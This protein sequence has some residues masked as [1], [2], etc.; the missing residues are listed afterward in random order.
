MKKDRFRFLKKLFV[1][2]LI[3]LTSAAMAG[4]EVTKTIANGLTS[5]QSGQT[6]TYKLQYR[7]ASTT[8]DFYST[9]LTDI[10]PPGIEF[11]SLVGTVHM[12]SYTYNAGTR[13]L[14]IFFIDPL[15][16]GSTG[17][18]DVNVRFTPGSTPPG[19][20]ATNTATLAATNAP[21]F[22]SPPVTI[23]ATATNRA[24]AGKSL[25]G[26]SVPLDQNVT[27]QISANNNQTA[28][29][30][31]ATAVT[32]TDLL[33]PAA[34]F[35]SAS[36][37]GAYDSLSHTVTWTTPTLNAGSSFT[38]TLTL[39]FPSSA[40]TLGASV[41]N[42]LN[43]TLTPLGSAPITLTAK[44]VNTIVAPLANSSF[45]K[46][47]N[48]SYV[49]E[50][51]TA[52]KTW[53]FLLQNTGNVPLSNVVVTDAIPQQVEVTSI[54]SG[55]PSGTPSG[56]N[57]PIGLFYQTTLNASWT[58][59]PGSP[60][61]GTALVT[62]P[63]SSLGLAPGEHVNAIKWEFGT[64][65][66]GYSINNLQFRSTI[67]TNDWSDQP[68]V[69][70]L[71]ITNIGVLAYTDFTGSKI[72]TDPATITVKT[73]RPVAELAKSASPS[74]VNDGSLTTF[75][76][77]LTNRSEAAQPLENPVLADLLDSKL[78]YVPGSWTVLSK[79]AGAPDPVFEMIANFTGSQ[80]LLR[81]KWDGAAAYNL[82][83][84]SY[85]EMR[86]QA[87]V[88]AGTI[89][90][91]INNDLTLAQ[92]G[93]TNLDVSNVSSSTDTHDLD[94]DG[95]TSETIYFKR[96]SITV[97]AR[98]SMDSVKWVK[99]QLDDQWNKY[100]TNGFT[101]PGGLADYRLIVMNTGNV[102]I[103]NA[104]VL[105]ILP[106]LDDTGVIDLSQRHT[107]WK[108]SLAGP[109]VAPPGV[110]VYY[111]RE[112][113]PTRLDF[114]PSGPPGSDPANWNATPPATLIEARS[115][116]F[117]FS[118]IVIQPG[119]SYEL[120]WPMRA[121]VETPTDGR[122]AWNS[123]GYYGTRTDSGANLLAS[124][125][126]KVGIAV[127]PDTNAI[128]GDQVWLDLNKDGIQDAGEP[129][130]NGIRVRLYEDSGPSGFPDG[131]I[132][133]NQDKYIGFTITADDFNGQSGYYLF[134]NLDRGN[135]YAVFE[136]PSG[137]GVSPK[138]AGTDDA[139]DSDVDALSGLTPI[140]WLDDAE[141]D[142]TWDLGLFLPPTGVLIV[143][144]AGTAPDGGVQWILP[145]S[146]VTY[147]YRVTNTGELALVR[148][149]VT[150]DKLGLIGEIAGP[151][152]P[153]ASATLT[154]TSSALHAGVTN[155]AQVVGHPA[156]SSGHEIPGAP[157]V[158]DDDPAI[159]EVYASIGDFV[160]YDVNRNG[161]QDSGEAG[162]GGVKVVLHDATGSPIATN[163][164]ASNG[165]YHFV[166][167]M[168]GEYSLGFTPPDDYVISPLDQ[169]SND[170]KDSDADPLTGR[171]LPTQLVS[172]ENDITWD[173]GLWN[174]A[175]IGDYAWY[176]VN[177]NGIQDAGET[178][179]TD[180]VVT[181]YD[182]AGTAVATTN[183]D[184]AGFYTFTH[185]F[186]GDYSVG[187][188]P[189]PG[190]VFSPADQG[191]NNAKDSDADR[192]TGQTATTS[193]G[194]GEHDMTWDAGLWLPASIGNYVWNDVNLNGIQDAG[195]TGVVSVLVTLFNGLD[196]VVATT[197]TDATGYY[198]F[199]G[200]VPGDY[201]VGFSLPPHH[202]FSPQDADSD[203]AKD[204]DADTTTGRT[205][206]TTLV[207]GEN[208]LTWDAGIVLPAS[209]GDF[210]WYDNNYNSVQD[211]GEPG[212][213]GIRV[214][215]YSGATLVAE[216][217]TDGTGHYLFR[218][219]VAGD[220]QVAFDLSTIPHDYKPTV[221]GP[222]GSS[223]PTDSDADPLTGRTEVTGLAWGENDLSW[224]L[225][226]IRKR[227]DVSLT[228]TALPIFDYP[229]KW[230]I[231]ISKG[232]QFVDGDYWMRLEYDEPSFD[233]WGTGNLKSGVQIDKSWHHVAGRFT[234][235]PTAW[236][237]HTMDI[238]VDGV[239]VATKTSSGTQ[240]PS[241][242][243]LV[244]GAYLGNSSF[245]GGLM[246]EVR[247]SRGARSDAWLQATVTQQKNPAAFVTLG[248]ELPGILPGYAH[249]RTL[250]VNG[251]LV[252]A[253]LTNFPVLV[254][255]NEN[256]LLS[257]VA[258]I[259][260]SD[261]TFTLTDGTVLPH[262]IELFRKASGRLVA[263]VKLP[264]LAAGS[265]TSFYLHYGNPTPPA[266]AFAPTAVWDDG[267]M[268]VQHFEE[269]SG[270]LLDSTTNGND[271]TI[272]G[273]APSTYGITDGAY[274][275]NGTTDKITIP[276]ND[277]IRLN[278]S[279]F[280]IEAW[281]SRKSVDADALFSI[282]VRN[283]GPD[284]AEDL[285]VGD[286]LAPSFSLVDAQTSQGVFTMPPGLW[287]VGDLAAGASATLRIAVDCTTNG[288]L[289]NWAEVA[290]CSTLDP[291]ST[292]NNGLTG[293]DDIASAIAQSVALPPEPSYGMPDFAVTQV[294]FIPSALTPGGAFAAEITV[295]NQGDKS[296]NA[297]NMTVWVHHPVFASPGE[298][299]D[300]NVAIGILAPGETRVV[301]VTGFT[302]PSAA[303][304]YKFRAYIDNFNITP[305]TS[306]GNN[307][308]KLTFFI[309]GGS[310]GEKPD[311]L[312][313]SITL[314]PAAPTAGGTITATVNVRNSG[315]GAGNAG[316]LRVW[317][318]KLD[319]ALPGEPGQAE[320]PIGVLSSGQ[321]TNILVT[322]LT[323]PTATG[324][325]HLRAF[326]D[327][328][329]SAVEQ[330]EGNNQ[331]TRTYSIT[332]VP[333][334]TAAITVQA[335][336][337]AG[338]SASGGGT[339]TVGSQT[340]LSATA[341]TNWTFTGWNDGNT[342]NPRTIT[343]PSGGAGY[344][345][346][347]TQNSPLPP[348]TGDR[349]VALGNPGA[350]APYT[351]WAIAASTI[352]AAVDIA[353]S[354]EHV[355]VSNGV[356]TL[357]CNITITNGVTVRSVNG[358]AVTTIDGSHA[359]RC[360]F[361]DHA[362]AVLDGFT[363]KNGYNPGGFGGGV[364]INTGGTVKNCI[365]RDNQ[366]RDGGGA[367]LDNGGLVE[368]CIVRDNL[369]SDNGSSG[370]GGG[371]RILNGGTVRGC[372]MINNRSLGLG[373]GLNVWEA[374]L[375][376]NCTVI[377][378]TAPD[379][380][381]VRTRNRGTVVNSVV[382]FNNG[383]DCT[384]D[385]SGYVYSNTCTSVAGSLPGSGNIASAPQFVNAA[386]DDFRLQ[387]TSPCLNT[388]LNAAWMTGAV[389]L[390]GHDRIAAGTVDM[391]AY[392]YSVV[393]LHTLNA[394]AGS[395]GGI[396]PAG[397]VAVVHGASQ[398]FQIVPNQ[399]YAVLD[400]LVDGLSVGPVTARTFTA[401]T[402][403]H[404]IS[405]TFTSADW[406]K[407]D[408][409]VLSIIPT[410]APTT[411]GALFSAAVT[412]KNQGDI[413]G[414]AG[415]LKLWVS[416][417]A[418]ALPTEMAD[419]T[420][421]IGVLSAGESR[422]LT[423]A[424][425]A[426]PATA[427]THNIRAF[428]DGGDGTVEKSE[429]NN[430]KTWTYT[431]GSSS[432]Q[433]PDFVI[434]SA[435]LDP[436]PNVTERLFDARVTVL[437]KGDS[438]GNGGLLRVWASHGALAVAGEPGDAEKTVG[439]LA[440]NESR[441]FLFSGLTS[442]TN[443]GTHLFRAFVDAN[444]ST[445]EKSDGNNQENVTYKTYVIRVTI[446]LCPG[447]IQLQWNSKPNA[448]YKVLR[449]HQPSGGFVVIATG[450]AATPPTNT[451]IDTAP[452]SPSYYRIDFA[453]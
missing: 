187:F 392:E 222:T 200:L 249:K 245:F 368:N 145:G 391:G 324:T 75:T 121:P 107:E 360:V 143:K 173:L 164:T 63:V 65:P 36:G 397:N 449:S 137:Y 451:Y 50:G 366:A 291:D 254:S 441:T 248:S 20:V 314:D 17:E 421:A 42:N 387:A 105:D 333:V 55:L 280:T 101:V 192:S 409:A 352:Q 284:L 97:F 403:D 319:A 380:A 349:Y 108:T 417:T 444:N 122:I 154:K 94:N 188:T 370:Y 242:A 446:D 73:P 329:D 306:E 195:E 303:G 323:A 141:T 118:G 452:S 140:T 127:Q 318:S 113:D 395:N 432:A 147:T 175:S 201:S 440:V 79:P 252:T 334:S 337:A 184:T 227:A 343:V 346:R 31:N 182:A 270:P 93:N 131:L 13:E 453:P 146:L 426:A 406:R 382:Y 347:F 325:H 28:G 9:T 253:D 46:D 91:G 288:P 321:S 272:T 204:S 401:V 232:E 159:V 126:I 23:T 427:G 171:T 344:T 12:A 362:N 411:T 196:Q 100:P 298:S 330:S 215:L 148:L 279:N 60:F 135:Y 300:K 234:R 59:A 197:N 81:W 320:I 132:D 163:T 212:V 16:A 110:T 117:V 35:V 25:V 177:R 413:A 216:Q 5:V 32:M 96:A 124:E 246:D 239:V 53:T 178:G 264:L 431:I 144:T 104:T 208:D 450:I 340:P 309:E 425:L 287:S 151:L 335:D 80:T 21:S 293:E 160:W 292:P 29:A 294:T 275:F 116:K 263:W 447:G 88:P 271:G 230:C 445:V 412:V 353:G 308:K 342:N 19:T 221:K 155:V 69:A 209:I 189:P 436:V 168:P 328:D 355:L 83:I 102:P 40:F 71:T 399:G 290:S 57:D 62:V 336:P 133:T 220:Y 231:P 112:Q 301:T 384:V 241:T 44:T 404:T 18:I 269:N 30:L 49:Y 339:F 341:N 87:Q 111:S 383:T 247:L 268:M 181:L 130:V 76:I 70:G 37:G 277:S 265:P 153:G 372:L 84:N 134:P 43:V 136:I 297:G 129:G 385:G 166:G 103:T 4:L 356:Y 238:L 442:T 307:Q 7:A 78:V 68:V 106:T 402:A 326:M 428:A 120:T 156:D 77:R 420:Q 285:V 225:G 139:K 258:T 99:G 11:Q 176:D 61:A 198:G 373:G 364:N 367:A 10:L 310:S 350:Q 435:S 419:S 422:T 410:P 393:T 376:E 219:L 260:G 389:D 259:D 27:Y 228:K 429:G 210:V 400:V 358:A 438:A 276:D 205:I 345:A 430:Q 348:T 262:E 109:V 405:A 423:I 119:A 89:Y 98:A 257:D 244:L 233:V 8:T 125:P 375:I 45:A 273:A 33:P 363:V 386:A 369:A 180:V 439:T 185:L 169:G 115:L 34:V 236:G 224:D 256:F 217:V 190:Y 289:T 165:Q 56:L 58:A 193:L 1:L 67:L 371:V 302:V 237:P 278:S 206:T 41:T 255:L 95:N 90:G 250:T 191:G 282:T 203:D 66:V 211:A 170:A 332:T 267:F 15:P 251:S 416:K 26:N 243:P 235:G 92:W 448:T 38:R 381:G 229:G 327:A 138:D 261:L 152:A 311:F 22:T 351:T 374:G 304:I 437:N 312:V 172:G 415:L 394:Q 240:D 357:A 424:G 186:P 158:R 14:K 322:T 162:I 338:G 150:D 407:A 354:G 174:L 6:F 390:D 378:N 414:D 443:A 359:T 47:V 214:M 86:F 305:E 85:I 72:K 266:P 315:P 194:V 183:T 398:T 361:I 226:I 418:T 179:I 51:K 167:L 434:T 52:S 54:N 365:L 433:K 39:L 317:V 74:T 213:P 161:I 199:T 396:T 202:I 142:R 313:S 48:A 207:P 281:F 24:T 316:I 408:F 379:G 331:L 295:V 157:P 2:T 274:A 128:Y 114:D 377:S 283:D 64:L 223:D 149:D 388:G 296:G 123:F 218:S 299:G 82:P 286:A 3:G